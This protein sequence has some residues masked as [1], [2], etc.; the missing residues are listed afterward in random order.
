M[1]AD[2]RSSYVSPPIPGYTGYIPHMKCT[3]VGIGRTYGAAARKGI[4]KVRYTQKYVYD[5]KLEG[6]VYA[7]IKWS[8]YHISFIFKKGSRMVYFVWFLNDSHS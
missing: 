6:R 1:I 4:Q 5:I 7:Y 2:A 3:E 8:I